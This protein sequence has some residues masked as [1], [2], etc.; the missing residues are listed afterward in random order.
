MKFPILAIALAAVSL[1]AFAGERT[2]STSKGFVSQDPELPYGVGWYAAIQAGINAH[3][4]TVDDSSDRV[5]NSIRFSFED[6]SNIG[7]FVGAKLGYVFGTGKIRPA[8]EFDGYYNHFDLDVKGHAGPVDFDFGGDVD[9][10]AFL[11]NFLVRFDFGRFQPYIGAG[12]G[13]HHTEASDP[14]A[15]VN[16]V[17][18]EGT[19]DS[20]TDFAWQI[21]AGSD[22]YFTEKLSLFLE[23][24][25]LNY[26]GTGNEIID[27]RI[28]QHLVGLGIRYHF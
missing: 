25:Y 18:I 6:D 28:D 5:F 26:E 22:Y 17:T 13:V 24:K 27:H 15:R 20:V 7:G 4:N 19:G 23:Y 2:V 9:S 11:I 10:G 21:V 1:P 3:Q 12:A 8:I 14:V 16:G